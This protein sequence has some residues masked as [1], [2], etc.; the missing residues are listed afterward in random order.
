MKVRRVVIDANVL[1]SAALLPAGASAQLVAHVLAHERLV[2]SEA[3]YAE[4]ATRLHRPKFDRYI[5]LDARQS[6][7]HDLRA[8]VDWV[9]PPQGLGPQRSRD[10]RDDKFVVVGLAAGAVL[11]ASGDHDLL[12][13][14]AIERLPV[15]APVP[16]LAHLQR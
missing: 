16:A 1:I 6:I 2:F 12:D 13:L 4:L 14:P 3:T 10:P 15:L 5:T 7:L 8:V 11:L 9:E